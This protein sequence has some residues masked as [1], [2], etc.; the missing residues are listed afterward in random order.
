[1]AL[2]YICPEPKCVG[3]HD[4]LV[5]KTQ[6]YRDGEIVNGLNVPLV[7][8][9]NPDVIEEFIDVAL[10]RRGVG[11]QFIIACAGLS[12]RVGFKIARLIEMSDEL[13]I[14]V[15]S[16]NTFSFDVIAAIARALWSNTSVRD[17]TLT[18]MTTCTR[19]TLADAIFAQAL[20]INPLRPEG[21]RWY[22][23]D[24]LIPRNDYPVLLA[25]SKTLPETTMLQTL[26]PCFRARF[27][28]NLSPRTHLLH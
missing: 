24:A 8:H 17:L 15:L 19:S 23:G 12:S 1:M 2:E 3:R 25:K 18:N 28:L 4:H 13:G 7:H 14:V 22:L 21:S 6:Q 16:Y 10:T 20:K 11:I 9:V 27:S 26:Y 5:L